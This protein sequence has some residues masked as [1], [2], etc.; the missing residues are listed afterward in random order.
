MCQI[1]TVQMNSRSKELNPCQ[2][3]KIISELNINKA[4]TKLNCIDKC[5]VEQALSSTVQYQFEFCIG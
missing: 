1:P 2:R 3:H 5:T 4:M